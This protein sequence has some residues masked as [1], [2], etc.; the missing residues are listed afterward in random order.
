[1][2]QKESKG[3]LEA[4]VELKAPADGPPQQA[5]AN[6]KSS[7]PLDIKSKAAVEKADGSHSQVTNPAQ[8]KVHIRKPPP[9]MPTMFFG[10]FT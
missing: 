9:M 7:K 1:M 4:S 6:R 8:Q 3:N 5:Q 2:V 10:Q